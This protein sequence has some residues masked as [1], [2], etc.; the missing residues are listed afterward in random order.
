MKNSDLFVLTS[1]Y[2]GFANVIVE[3]V[4]L[5]TPVISANCNSG[6]S[7]I[8]L[9]GKGGEL[10]KPNS[11]YSLIKKINKFLKNPKVLK[12]KTIQ[13]KKLLYRF[14]KIHSAKIYSKVFDKI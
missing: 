5:N 10:Y 8:L 14:D 1:K 6:P 12:S 13:A 9:N 2:E 3:S 11:I 4:V 7:E